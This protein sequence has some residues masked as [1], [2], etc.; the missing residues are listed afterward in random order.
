MNVRL[1]IVV[2]WAFAICLWPGLARA[3]TPESPEV[4]EVIKKA[5][6]FLDEST[7]PRLGGK[8]LIGLAYLKEG[9][10]EQHPKVADAA[11]A[12]QQ[13]AKPA[14]DQIKT[15][16]YSTGLAI[17]FLCTL[18]PSKY[19]PEIL[20][21]RESLE[22]RQKP[23]GGWG[24]PERETG[25]TSMTQY[26]VLAYWEMANVG[27]PPSLDSTERVTNWILRTQDPEGNWGYQGREGEEGTK[28]TLVKQDPNRLGM[29][30]AGL[31]CVYM[32]GDLLKLNEIEAERDATL[33]PALKPVKQAKAG[34][35]TQKVNPRFLLAAQDR[36]RTW[37]KEHY[38][39][40]PPQFPH[41]YL[42]ALERYQSFYEAAE[43]RIIKEPKWYN[44]GYAYL[45][46][47]Q[48]DNG[49]WKPQT[50]GMEA[51][52]AAFGVLFLLRSTKKAIERAKSFGDG[53]MLAG[54]GL[55]AAPQ[56]VRTRGGQIVE[57]GM[58]IT[59]TQLIDV[60]FQPDHPQLHEVASDVELLR[61]KLAALSE[62]E[63]GEQIARLRGLAITGVPETRLAAVRVLG[64]ARD[65]D[66]AVTLIAT[67]SDPDWRVVQAADES[68]RFL[69]RKVSSVALGEKPNGQ[70]RQ[71]AIDHWKQWFLALRPDA[72]FDN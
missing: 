24:Y 20:K 3:V 53:E 27:F 71:T 28:L 32:A 58:G 63:R 62:R 25:D 34:G 12:C 40:D 55:P 2:G 23:H 47:E 15:D 37:L 31:G 7:E 67:L 1:R 21:F 29:T 52:T 50:E 68:L 5:F 61:D 9:A 30:T 33:P 39:I 18:N 70:V 11:K 6:T 10:D 41:Y 8:C 56:A 42:Y 13:H 72:E 45:K 59:A 65:L 64:L 57:Q 44:D 48:L 49:S 60:L 43:G 46:R 38:K 36:G 19:A 4:R 17:I 69:G 16:I 66:G 22:Y 26:G 54:R 14:G 35:L 51:V